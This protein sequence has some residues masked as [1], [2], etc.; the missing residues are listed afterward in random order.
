MTVYVDYSL[1]P[2]AISCAPSMLRKGQPWWY[3]PERPGHFTIRVLDPIESRATDAS[4]LSE[5]LAAH[6]LSAT[7][8]ERISEKLDRV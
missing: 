1:Q 4:D 6:R 7:L 5:G 8:R 2:V 3:V